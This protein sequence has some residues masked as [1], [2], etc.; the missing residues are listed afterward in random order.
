M[1]DRGSASVLVA[2]AGSV[3]VV[4]AAGLAAVGAARVARHQAKVAADFGA[5][6]GGAHAIEGQAAACAVARRYVEANGASMSDCVVSGLEIVVRA[7]VR[8]RFAPDGAEAASRAGPISG[9]T[10]PT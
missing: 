2:A 6:A 9:V 8:F 7:E 4:L 3:L 5:L 10:I 1:R